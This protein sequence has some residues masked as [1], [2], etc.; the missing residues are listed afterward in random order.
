MG[1]AFYTLGQRKGLR[2][3]GAGEAWFVIGKDMERSVVYV[4]Q[5]SDHPALYCE[6]LFANELSWVSGKS[7]SLPFTCHSKV[8]YRQTDQPCVIEKI[9]NGRAW[10]TFP[11][12]QRAVTPGQSIVFY[13][14]PICLGGGI[15]ES[16]DLLFMNLAKLCRENHHRGSE[17]TEEK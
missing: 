12:P 15:I 3:G 8:R 14:G 9:E 10:I 17:N 7:P 6:E 1:T 16:L 5:G 4:T 13:D 2:I 11:I